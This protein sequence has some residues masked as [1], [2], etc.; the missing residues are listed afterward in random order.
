VVVI[1][2]LLT[3]TS[4]MTLL[5]DAKQEAHRWRLDTFEPRPVALRAVEVPTAREETL[6]VAC[7]S[8]HVRL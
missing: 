7:T 2:A 1:D 8:R 5:S 3:I 4:S 6:L